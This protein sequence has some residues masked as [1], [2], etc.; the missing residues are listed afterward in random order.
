MIFR[1]FSATMMGVACAIQV[2]A[3]LPVAAGDT[4]RLELSVQIETVTLLMGQENWVE[5]LKC[6]EDLVKAHGDDA[7]QSH[8][9]RFGVVY[10]RKGVCELK[11]KK[12]EAAMKSFETCYKDFPNKEGQPPGLGNPFQKTCLMQWAEA[13]IGAEDWRLALD[14]YKKFLKERDLERDEYNKGDLYV[15]LAVCHYNLGDIANGN[16]NL[17]I[18]ISN[19]NRFGVSSESIF[20]ALGR[21]LDISIKDKKEQALL[22]FI[23]KNRSD[24]MADAFDMY[25]F[26]GM[27]MKKAKEAID[28]K[29]HRAAFEIYQLVPSPEMAIKDARERLQR[30]GPV[31]QSETGSGDALSRERLEKGIAQIEAAEKNGQSLGMV[32]LAATAYLHEHF[33]NLREAHDG[34]QQLELLYSM[35]QNREDN[36][37]N[38]ARLSFMVGPATDGIQA[39]RKFL[40]AYP[41]SKNAPLLQRLMLSGL[42]AGHQYDEC[43]ASALDW[44]NTFKQ[45]SAQHDLCLHV[46]GG[47]YFYT[48]QHE[49]AQKYLKQHV[50]DY[51]NSDTAIAA[52][53]FQASN[54]F[55]L[56]HHAEAKVLLDAFIAKYPNAAENP[57]L[58]YACYDRATVYFIGNQKQESL[59]MTDDLI[60]N[61]GESAVMDQ[62]HNLRGDILRSLDRPLDAEGAYKQSL[63]LSGRLGHQMVAGLAICNL[64]DLLVKDSKGKIEAARHGELV[65]YIDTFWSKYAEDSPHAS[66]IAVIQIPVLEAAN[67]LDE[68]L[69]R[70]RNVITDMSGDPE[71]KGLEEKLDAYT[72][73][74]LKKH[75][76]D[77]LKEHYLNFPGVTPAAR[78]ARALLQTQVIGVYQ[79]MA[80]TTKDSAQKTACEAMIKAS[81]VRLK[82]DFEIKDLPNSALSRLADYLRVKTATP[83]EALPFYDE[84]IRRG[85][86]VEPHGALLGR[87]DVY[88]QSGNAV[89]IDKALADLDR[90]FKSTGD[91]KEKEFALYRMVELL[92]AKKDFPAASEKANLYLNE[93]Q[94]RDSGNASMVGLLLAKSFEGREMKEEAI[95]MYAKTWAASTDP[96]GV[97]APAM[98]RYMELLWARN[99]PAADANT[100]GDRQKAYGDAAVYINNTKARQEQMSADDL[101]LW[102]QV[103]ALMQQY[104][105]N[106]NIKSLEQLD[107][108]GK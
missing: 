40:A 58:P 81:F 31:S 3:A 35:A 37:F 41:N 103:E 10:F 57:F 96:I 74:Y 95:A 97:S 99:T 76:L 2:M 63:V 1:R 82:S 30:L 48:G 7:M 11:L 15:G 14:L 77:Q 44:L 52:A 104:E 47:S 54:E 94:D 19:K 106:P 39:A 43:I 28:A 16:E 18:A 55:R 24:L 83:R 13:A 93:A 108:E 73:A 50:A 38:L 34:Y 62:V 26:A 59:Q 71:A 61:F 9:A 20:G 85:D 91:A 107:K 90:V 46:L 42:F 84:M 75:T 67:R 66:E 36:L 86:K 60:A 78:A 5:A 98:K 4:D 101:E 45:G 23:A 21:L 17:E 25:A 79:A 22:D 105:A 32:K 64:I 49:Q 89:D 27:F 29:M 88:G 72:A 68:A 33:G 87:A 70:L 12:W 8:D 51:P 65:G 92:V 100:P 53:Y 69:E 56:N 102:K 80:K 6:S